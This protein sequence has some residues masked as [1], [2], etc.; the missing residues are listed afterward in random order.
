MRK[1]TQAFRRPFWFAL[2]VLVLGASVVFPTFRLGAD[3]LM[4]DDV[5]KQLDRQQGEF[6]S[7]SANMERAEVTVVVNDRST[8]SGQ[9]EGTPR[10]Q[11]AR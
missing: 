8:E 4:V 6:R 1:L 5:L 7:L 3:P 2:T 9:I 11:N 10:W